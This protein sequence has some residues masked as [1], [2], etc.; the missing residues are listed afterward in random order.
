MGRYVAQTRALG[1]AKETALDQTNKTVIV[2]KPA[3]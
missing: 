3:D 2:P 1:W